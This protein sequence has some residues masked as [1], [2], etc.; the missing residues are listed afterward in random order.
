MKPL[1]QHSPRP[2]SAATSPNYPRSLGIGLALAALSLGTASCMGAA[3]SPYRSD[4]AAP[5]QAP[6]P[7]TSAGPKQIATSPTAQ[8]LPTTPPT[9]EPMPAG[10]ISPPFEEE[11]K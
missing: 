2:R 10:G 1:S 4:P 3:P 9:N 8:P 7:M 5:G 6:A 11:K